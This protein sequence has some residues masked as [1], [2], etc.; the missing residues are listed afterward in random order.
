M[1]INIIEGTDECRCFSNTAAMNV[2]LMLYAES[3]KQKKYRGISL[4]SGQAVVKKISVFNREGKKVPENAH[5][6][7]FDT[8]SIQCQDQE[9]HHHYPS[10]KSVSRNKLCSDAN[11]G[12]G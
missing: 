10:C 12:R 9:E 11:P 3:I 2:Y 4:P 1:F 7:W 6:K 5:A 8:A